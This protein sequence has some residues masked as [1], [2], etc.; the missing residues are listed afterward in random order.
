MSGVWRFSFGNYAGMLTGILPSS[1]TPILVLRVIDEASAAYYAIAAM[2]VSLVNVIASS[3][4]Q[5]LFNE[6]QHAPSESGALRR[7]AIGT[8]VVLAPAVFLGLIL[9]PY[10]LQV[11][12]EDYAA[13]GTTLLRLMLLATVPSALSYLCDAVIN[14]RG[15]ST[16]YFFLN[17]QN[18]LAVLG[19][20]AV[21][22][23]FDLAGVGLGWLAGQTLASLICVIYLL[24]ARSRD[25][26][27]QESPDV[28]PA[29]LQ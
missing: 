7:S 27:P 28:P 15:D 22:S 4:G 17:V 5:S 20:V 13:E 21:G 26:R 19:G 10:V 14:A 9:A 3:M 29:H 24:A 25:L 18:A 1:L 2:I 8:G 6:A 12:G 16:G 23:H 11:F